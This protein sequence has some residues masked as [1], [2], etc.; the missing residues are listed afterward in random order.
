MA[1]KKTTTKKIVLDNNLYWLYAGLLIV[2]LFLMYQLL[3]SNP[4]TIPEAGYCLEKNLETSYT[5]VKYYNGTKEAVE[6]CSLETFCDYSTVSVV[7][8]D[9]EFNQQLLD[10]FASIYEDQ[11]Y[12]CFQDEAPHTQRASSLL[13]S[14][15]ESR[16]LAKFVC[17]TTNN[18]EGNLCPGNTCN[19]R[20]TGYM[21]TNDCRIY[22]VEQGFNDEGFMKITTCGGNPSMIDWE[23]N[24]LV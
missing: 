12:E 23:A 10:D 20:Y 19:G 24:N 17:C 21:D 3:S 1:K 18:P 7:N 13:F 4:L 2:G 15:P 22:A 5:T 9:E 14:K 8:E 16:Q 6:Y 11:G